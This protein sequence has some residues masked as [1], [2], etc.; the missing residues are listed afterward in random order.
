MSDKNDG[1]AFRDTILEL[2][3]GLWQNLQPKR[4]SMAV[5]QKHFLLAQAEVLKGFTKVIEMELENLDK[6]AGKS[7][8]KREKISVK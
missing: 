2:G 1:A 4:E 8:A 5:L 7:S 3:N 6:P